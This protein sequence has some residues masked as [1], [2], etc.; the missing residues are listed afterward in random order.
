MQSDIHE[1][2]FQHVTETDIINA[3]IGKKDRRRWGAIQWRR[4]WK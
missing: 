2:D 1:L 3:A 4:T